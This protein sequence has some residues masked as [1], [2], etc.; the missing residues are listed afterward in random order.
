[1]LAQY[2]PM[3]AAGIVPCSPSIRRHY[4]YY[5]E[6]SV[7]LSNLLEEELEAERDWV[8]CASRGGGRNN[9]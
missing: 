7:G 6:P 2:H 3:K 4:S 5:H 8:V 1:M 9:A